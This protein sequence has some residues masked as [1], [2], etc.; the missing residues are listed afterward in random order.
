MRLNSI[1]GYC[2]YQLSF[3]KKDNLN[4]ILSL[5][6]HNPK[7]EEFENI[8]KWCIKKG[9]QFIDLH[10]FL[11]TLKSDNR[12]DHKVAY[13]SLDDGW[14][15]NLNLIPIIEKYN[16]PITIFVPIEPLQSGN[17]WWEYVKKRHPQ[18]SFREI[19]TFKTYSEEKFN[20]TLSNLKN[21]TKL[22]R[23]SISLSELNSISQHPLIE[24]QSHSF[25]HPILTNLSDQSL[26]IELKGSK[27]FLENF[28]NKRIF[29]FSYPNGSLTSREIDATKRYYECAFS[30][31][32]AHPK[33]GSDLYQIPRVALS[34]NY[35]S[36]LAKITGGW[37]LISKLKMKLIKLILKK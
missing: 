26:E 12:I 34:N 13:I 25:N 28:L 7:P 18:N 29:A 24:I 30:T 14:K 6:F 22:E 19:Q 15:D 31:I 35:W 37:F 21:G 10:T 11:T 2:L 20:D 23:S 5:Y 33:K 36:N 27:D 17:Y 3:L 32:Q 1:L 9:Y 8:I 4:N 16:V